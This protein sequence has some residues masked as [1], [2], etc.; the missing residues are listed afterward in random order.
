MCRINRGQAGGILIDR[1]FQMPGRGFLARDRFLSR[2]SATGGSNRGKKG[3]FAKMDFLMPG[4]GFMA[5]T[6]IFS[7]G[8]VGG[9]KLGSYAS[10]TVDVM[11]V[12]VGACGVLSRCLAM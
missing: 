6:G 11:V 2:V 5:K 3:L 4:R 1:Y 9:S 7:F 8:S 10:N 12:T